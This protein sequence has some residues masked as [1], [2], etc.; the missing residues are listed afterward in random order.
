MSRSIGLWHGSSIAAYC[1]VH[2]PA[3]EGVEAVIRFSDVDDAIRVRPP[4]R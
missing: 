2:D 3:S 4:P 1:F